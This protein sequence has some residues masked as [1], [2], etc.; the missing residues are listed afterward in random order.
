M[1]HCYILALDSLNCY[2][3]YT[4]ILSEVQSKCSTVVY[5]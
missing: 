1:L 4:W 5:R 2:L 3:N